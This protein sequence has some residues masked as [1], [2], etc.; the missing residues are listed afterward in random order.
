MPMY[1]ASD[2]VYCKLFIKNIWDLLFSFD[3]LPISTIMLKEMAVTVDTIGTS[4]IW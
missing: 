4:V 3:A 2:S 1:S